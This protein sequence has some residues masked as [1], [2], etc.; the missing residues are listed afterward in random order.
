M[1]CGLQL[2]TEHALEA[3]VGASKSGA[4]PFL[5]RSGDG[6]AGWLDMQVPYRKKRGKWGFQVSGG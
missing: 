3:A 6:F 1:F 5:L 2:C 4:E